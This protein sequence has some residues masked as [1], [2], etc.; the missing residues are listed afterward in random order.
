MERGV[1]LVLVA[2]LAM[3]GCDRKPSRDPAPE[4]SARE[5]LRVISLTP[6]ATDLMVELGATEM[7][8]GVDDYTTAPEAADLPRVGS[9]LQPNLEAIMRLAPDLVIADDVHADLEAALR[10]AGIATLTCP[11]HA[12]PDVRTGLVKVGARIDREEAAEAA[13]KRIDVAIDAAGARTRANQPGVLAVIDSEVG[14]L[15]NLVAAGPG[16]WL[17]ELIAIEG[18]R[19]A[20]VASGVRYPK[21]SPEEVLRGA[22]DVILD[23]SFVATPETI[24]ADWSSVASVP[25]VANG[26]VRVL[27][28]PFLQRPSPRVADALAALESALYD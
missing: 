17:D 26:R 23:T 20:L 12:L 13:V 7:L 3:V 25:A 22:P 5:T 24:A 27:R 8:V 28:E 6:S 2:A 1:Q 16:S 19:N 14:G 4:G 18:G 10:D 15:G 21:I 9:F 11:M